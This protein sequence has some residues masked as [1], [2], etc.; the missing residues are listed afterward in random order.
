LNKERQEKIRNLLRLKGDVTTKEL[1]ELFPESDEKAILEDFSILEQEGW[2]RQY[3]GG[4][5]YVKHAA[6]PTP[7]LFL[8]RSLLNA[9]QKFKM[10]KSALGFVERGRTI[11]VDSGTTMMYF[12]QEMPD[13]YLSVFT[14]GVNIAMEL[15]KRKKPSITLVGGQLNRNTVAVS[16]AYAVKMLADVNIDIAFL[17]AS[18]FDLEYGFTTGTYTECETKREAVNRAQTKIVLMDSSKTE[19]K[20]PFSFAELEEIDVL[21]TD[22]ALPEIIKKEAARKNVKVIFGDEI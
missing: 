4:A 7:E 19:I 14:P 1:L 15:I 17:A 21:I 11:F 20:R 6:Q 9:S 3:T 2:I 16:G 12:A 13:E 10:A 18:G 5:L 22:S 8:K